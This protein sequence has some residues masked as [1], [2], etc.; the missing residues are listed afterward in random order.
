VARD[1]GATVDAGAVDAGVM[2]A[3]VDAGV[4][5]AGFDAGVF[6]AGFDAGVEDAGFDAGFDAGVDAGQDAGLDAGVDAGTM[7]AGVCLSSQGPNYNCQIY[8]GSIGRTCSESCVW[9]PGSQGGA[10]AWQPG[11]NCAGDNAGHASCTY[12]W[13][14]AAGALPRWQCC[15]R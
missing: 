1:A 11:D 2:D 13:G 10:A 9:K 14:D 15:C 3:G 6:D 4:F 5:D 7:D 12:P 8:C